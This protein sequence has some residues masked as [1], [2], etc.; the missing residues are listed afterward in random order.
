MHRA[1]L[2][3]AKVKDGQGAVSDQGTLLMRS[4]LQVTGRLFPIMQ[5]G[6]LRHGGLLGLWEQGKVAVT[7]PGCAITSKP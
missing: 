6:K 7:C 2:L 3:H 5:V 1:K 4:Y